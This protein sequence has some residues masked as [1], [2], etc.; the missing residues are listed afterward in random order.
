MLANLMTIISLCSLRI[1]LTSQCFYLLNYKIWGTLQ[2]RVY[3]TKIKNVHEL[4][5][6][7]AD[8]RDKLDQRIVDKAVE[9]CRKRLRACVVAGGGL[10]EH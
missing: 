1:F 6:R 4:R 9:E 8:K 3:T 10:F 2:E 7:I 5:E